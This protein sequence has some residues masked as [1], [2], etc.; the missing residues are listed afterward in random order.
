MSSADAWVRCREGDLVWLISR[1]FFSPEF[2]MALRDHAR[3]MLAPAEPISR[4]DGLPRSTEL[5]RSRLQGAATRVVIKRYIPNNLWQSFKDVFR[6]SRARRGFQTAF[7]LQ[8]RGIAV[9]APVAAGEKRCCC[10][11]KEAFLISEEIPNA[12]TIWE[13]RKG[14]DASQKH[15]LA[16]ALARTLAQLHDAGFS[17][18]DPNFNNW[19][20]RG[21]IQDSASIVA[22]DLDSISKKDFIS[23][24]AAAKD[25][26]RLVRY[27]EPRER[28]WFVAQY[29][30]SR[31]MKLCAREFDEL[32]QRYI[33]PQGYGA[34]EGLAHGSSSAKV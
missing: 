34:A 32:C 13:H 21:S 9:A 20:V 3:L 14:A 5:V 19:L 7:A 17:H 10:W 24:R 4:W 22:I 23:T 1:E 25:L 15:Q 11:L 29:C 2:Q 12:R 28:L 8:E 31:K 18:S 33:K 30:R 6:R 26:H 27:M 16:R